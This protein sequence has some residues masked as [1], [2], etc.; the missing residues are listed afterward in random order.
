MKICKYGVTLSLLRQQD[1]E[2][3]SQ[4]FNPVEEKPSDESSD[5]T[6]D[7]VQE[8]IDS[9]YN[10]TNFYYIIEYEGIKIGLINDKVLDW[11]NRTSETELVLWDDS[12]ADTMAPM[13]AMLCLFETGFYYLG[14]KTYRTRAKQDDSKGI[15]TVK[16]LG[17]ELPED[18]KKGK[19]QEYSLSCKHFETK[20]K[21][22]LEEARANVN[23]ESG[24]GYLLLEAADYETGIAQKI[25]HH[26]TESGIYLHRKGKAG[27]RMY[28][29]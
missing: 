1:I 12:Y 25:E 14:W 29:R 3:V 24:E 9:I 22:I 28:F 2:F 6:P 8:W 7:D 11:R 15:E 4:K 5:N 21:K 19:D 23:E 18:S 20:A 27:S 26:I 13:L 17:F 16:S 10:F